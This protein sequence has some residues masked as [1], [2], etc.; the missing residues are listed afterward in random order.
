MLNMGWVVQTTSRLL[1]VAEGLCP[2]SW[3]WIKISMDF[4]ILERFSTIHCTTNR[5]EILVV[6][7]SCMTN[8]QKWEVLI[9]ILHERLP[10]S[11]LC[12][13]PRNLWF[14]KQ[15]PASHRSLKENSTLRKKW[16]HWLLAAGSQVPLGIDADIFFTVNIGGFH[17]QTPQ[18]QWPINQTH[19]HTSTLTS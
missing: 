5:K 4:P 14:S 8:F 1:L 6:N 15:N 17:P 2:L 9:W 13:L 7:N 3:D 12:F 16:N 18:L 19:T 11:S 10:N